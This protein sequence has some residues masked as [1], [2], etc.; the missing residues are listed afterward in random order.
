[1]LKSQSHLLDIV[2]GLAALCVF[3]AHAS[4]IA[5]TGEYSGALTKYVHFGHIG[6]VVFFVLSGFVIAFVMDFKH[7]SGT[8]YLVARFVR[9]YTVLVPCVLLTWL[10][11]WAGYEMQNA[12]YV[13]L[14]DTSFERVAVKSLVVFAMLGQSDFITIKYLS[15][16][17][18]WSIPY[19]FW[20]Y[21]IA[22]AAFYLRNANRV[23]M[24][25]LLLLAAGFKILLLLPV[26]LTGYLAY[27]Y[28]KKSELF[29]K[30]VRSHWLFLAF[31]VFTI[32]CLIQPIYADLSR[33]LLGEQALSR[34][35]F[36]RHFLH[37]YLLALAFS[38]LL[39]V[40][41]RSAETFQFGIIA[42]ARFLRPLIDMS[43]TMYLLHVPLMYFFRSIGYDSTTLSN[44]I[45]YLVLNLACCYCVYLIFERN[46]H[47]V[48]R[49]VEGLIVKRVTITRT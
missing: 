21:L 11:D 37:D 1:M 48:R 46:S 26:W 9:I 8:R 40:L 20:Y 27:G 33:H 31:C 39:I 23:L 17:P 43:F 34:L 22:G 38:F 15:N 25:V 29:T 5:Y 42:T 4:D 28:C 35:G 45:L 19:E 14:K 44:S 30:P 12:I 10:I 7:Q 13:Q 3:A 49:Y 16:G 41:L 2:R 24:V 18:L 47:Y 36:S 32:A 6:V